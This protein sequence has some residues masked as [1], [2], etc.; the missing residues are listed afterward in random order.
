MSV[1][2]RAERMVAFLRDR[3]TEDEAAARAAS[4]GGRWQVQETGTHGHGI[5]SIDEHEYGLPEYPASVFDDESGA[6]GPG[7]LTMQ[8]IARWDPAR[9]LAECKAK[10]LVLD[11]L[12]LSFEDYYLGSTGEAVV[13]E[14]AA[15]YD[16]H[17]DYD[18]DWRW[19]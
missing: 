6:I 13:S 12:D 1:D 9:V 3:I 2:G 15:V 16:D 10:R 7:V 8:H 17:P 18:P 11:Q 5:V 14:M 19:T 4:P